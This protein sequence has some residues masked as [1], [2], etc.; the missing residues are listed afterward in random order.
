MPKKKK[1]K[2]YMKNNYIFL[3]KNFSVSKLQFCFTFL[4]EGISYPSPVIYSF[5]VQTTMHHLCHIE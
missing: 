5:L 2:I 4:T 3:I 1:T